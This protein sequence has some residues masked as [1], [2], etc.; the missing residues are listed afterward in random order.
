MY[1]YYT[2][3]YRSLL[4]FGRFLNGIANHAFTKK[5]L[6]LN[7]KPPPGRYAMLYYEYPGLE[8]ACK[9]DCKKRVISFAGAFLKALA[10]Q[11]EARDSPY[12]PDE[13]DD[14][15]DVWTQRQ[16]DGF[17][18]NEFIN[19]AVNDALRKLRKL[20]LLQEEPPY[21]CRGDYTDAPFPWGNSDVEL[22]R[23]NRLPLFAMRPKGNP[24]SVHSLLE[25]FATSLG[26]SLGSLQ[27]A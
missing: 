8:K 24:S 3:S 14:P 18:Y 10:C 2:T 7:G 27:N 26:L 1:K 12:D 17:F 6:T 5:E 20:V 9:M 25:Q 21:P 11:A 13:P 16:I 22:Q 23:P 15:V 19:D 4:Y